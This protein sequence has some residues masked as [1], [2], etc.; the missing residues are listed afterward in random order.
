MRA[1]LAIWI[2]DR[3]LE[4]SSFLEM[5]LISELEMICRPAICLEAWGV[6]VRVH[7]RGGGIP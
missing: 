7:G 2:L 5:I 4:G 3:F 6:F 1:R